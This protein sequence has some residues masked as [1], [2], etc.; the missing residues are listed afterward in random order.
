MTSTTDPAS[1][2]SAVFLDHL[3]SEPNHEPFTQPLEVHLP[4]GHYYPQDL[5]VYS[6]NVVISGSPSSISHGKRVVRDVETVTSQLQKNEAFGQ[7]KQLSVMFDVWNSTFRLDNVGLFANTPDTAMS[8]IRSSTFVISRC[9]ITSCP[10]TSPFVVGHSGMESSVIVVSAA[11]GERAT[12]AVVFIA[13]KIKSRKICGHFWS[14]ITF[15]CGKWFELLIQ[16]SRRWNRPAFRFRASFGD[17]SAWGC[18]M[19]CVSVGVFPDKHNEHTCFFDH[20]LFVF[21]SGPAPDWSVS[22][23]ID[24][25]SLRDK[26]DAIGLVWVV[27]AV[28][29]FVL[30][31]HQQ[32]CS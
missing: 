14:W 26:R 21:V 16:A 4:A 7:A 19:L 30:F 1:P 11:S 17:W 22:V 31:L 6:Q 20:P 12:I 10:D 32:R 23:G 8:L 29:L 5:S 9:E 27:S 24:E 15:D 25:S 2:N 13:D 3:I 18:W 28:E